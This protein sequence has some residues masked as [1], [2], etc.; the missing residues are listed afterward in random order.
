M[1]SITRRSF[2]QKTATGAAVF[3]TPLILSSRVFGADGQTKP[4]NRIAM[5]FIGTGRQCLNANL[6][7]LLN[8]DDVQVVAVCDVDQWRMNV[9][10]EKVD[11]FY[12]E[13]SP[14]GSSKGCAMIADFRELLAR[15]DID[16]VMISTPDHWHVP[17]AMA[18][19]RAGKDVCCEKPLTRN[20]AEGRGLSDLVTKHKRVFR[21][22]S[23]FRSL[24]RFHH[25]AQVVRNGKIGKLT[26][27][28]TA[29]P[30]DTP[31]AMPADMPVPP[32]LNYDMWLGPAPEAAY[33]EQRVHPRHHTTARPGWITIRDYADGMIANWGAHLNDVAMWAND[34]E[35]TGPI[36]IEGTGHYPPAGNLWDVI[37]EFSI[38]FAFANGV[39]L[40]CKTD[41]P[42]IRF[43][44]SEGWFYVDWK[45]KMESSIP[46]L[47]KWKPGPKD[48]T[49]P[50]KRSEKR[51]FLDAVKTRG[52]TLCDAEVGHRVTSLAHLG[53]AAV[54]LGRK[55]K[56]DPVKED[57]VGN[58]AE[59]RALLKPKPA[60]APWAK[61]GT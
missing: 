37:Q 15:R 28:I 35:R 31:L 55:L 57:V 54:S 21:T 3:A 45:G 43:E 26:H 25:A 56:W 12:A 36:E 32:E 44:G 24:G 1:S 52:Q 47:V 59:A 49:L 34:T 42:Y 60:R 22:D 61:I 9:A 23:E 19:V 41:T 46:S 17:I 5:G 48:L 51:D 29:T 10:K 27:I 20:I 13:K 7:A 4:S 11:A 14:A 2:L 8:E 16:A 33:T 6:P 40:T 39:K 18:A 50:L 30:K 58:D 53:L 38:D